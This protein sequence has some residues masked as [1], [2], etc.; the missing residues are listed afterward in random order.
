[1][2]ASTVVKRQS[3][4]IPARLRCVCH[5]P[6]SCLK[7]LWSGMRRSR[8]CRFITPISISAIFSQLPCLGV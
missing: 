4:R 1:M 7:T 3:T 6:A 2:R 5:A 8:H